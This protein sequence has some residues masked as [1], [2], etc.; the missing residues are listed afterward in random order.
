VGGRLDLPGTGLATLGLR[1]LAFSLIEVGRAG[2]GDH[3]ADSAIA[4]GIVALVAFFAVQR[5]R[6]PQAKLSSKG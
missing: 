1:G 5:R 6:R 4:F 3:L 2:F